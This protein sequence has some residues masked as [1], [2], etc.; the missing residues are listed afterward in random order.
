MAKINHVDVEKR[1]E[2]AVTI[3]FRDKL[4]SIVDQRDEKKKITAQ[5]LQTGNFKEDTVHKALD[6]MKEDLR[7]LNQ[8]S[9]KAMFEKL[10][11]DKSLLKKYI[12]H[13]EK[14]SKKD[15]EAV[16]KIQDQIT[17]YTESMENIDEQFNEELVIKARKV[18]AKKQFNVK[19]GWFPV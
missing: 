1:L 13:P 17:Q 4:L 11:L 10:G 5:P 2:S 8:K 7:R 9:R 19:K 15:W 18:E 6:I 12:S 14:L 3:M 16:R